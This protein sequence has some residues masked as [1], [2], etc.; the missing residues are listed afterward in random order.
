MSQARKRHCHALSH[1]HPRRTEIF[2]QFEHQAWNYTDLIGVVL[3]YV[4]DIEGYEIETEDPFIHLMASYAFKLMKPHACPQPLYS[5]FH[6]RPSHPQ[7]PILLL[8]LLSVRIPKGK[9][10]VFSWEMTEVF[11]CEAFYD[12]KQTYYFSLNFWHFRGILQR[13]YNDIRNLKSSW[14][15]RHMKNQD[16][17][18][19]SWVT[20]LDAYQRYL[21]LT[22]INVLDCQRILRAIGNLLRTPESMPD[23][24]E[25]D[26]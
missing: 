21:P 23:F 17:K 4:T 13:F 15:Q 24:M 1:I 5:I 9:W 8:P 10:D 6:A 25:E 7:D 12:N 11:A 3:G 26:N 16:G 2:L 14:I 22:D 18:A 20:F 19:K